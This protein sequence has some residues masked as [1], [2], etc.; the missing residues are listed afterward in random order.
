[1]ISI[2]LSKRWRTSWMET[3]SKNKYKNKPL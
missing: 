2:T 1:M 3:S